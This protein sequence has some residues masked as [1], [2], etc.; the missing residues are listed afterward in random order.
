MYNW[1]NFQTEGIPAVV[2]DLSNTNNAN[3]SI[4]VSEA[5]KEVEEKLEPEKKKPVCILNTKNLKYSIFFFFY[6]FILIDNKL[7]IVYSGTENIKVLSKP[8]YYRSDFRRSKF[9]VLFKS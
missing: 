8:S 1:Y 9:S 3:Q 4:T 7:Y 2:E 5:T 6:F